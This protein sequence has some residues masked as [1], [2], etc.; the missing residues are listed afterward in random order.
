MNI[1]GKFGFLMVIAG[2]GASTV[3]AQSAATLSGRI[4][5]VEVQRGGAW[6]EARFSEEISP[7]ERVR[8]GD[9]S[10][11]AVELGPGKV[12]TLAENTEIEVRDGAGSLSV[13]LVSGNMRVVSASD[14][15]VSARDTTPESAARPLDLDLGSHKLNLTITGRTGP[16]IIRGDEKSTKRGS[17]PEVNPSQYGIPFGYSNMYGNPFGFSGFYTY[18]FVFGNPG[19]VQ[20]TIQN[21][22]SGITPGQIIPPMTDPLRP[23]VHFP[24]TTFPNRTPIR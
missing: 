17:Q 23:P 15:Q 19:F 2:L 16:I 10:S 12:A 6:T 8:T 9:R 20:P 24:I 14:I 11:A 22:Y 5:T 7:G 21:P 4:G 1:L 13:R 3:H 18:P